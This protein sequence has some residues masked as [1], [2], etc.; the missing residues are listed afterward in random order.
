MLCWI[1]FSTSETLIRLIIKFNFILVKIRVLRKLKILCEQVAS[2][3]C[4]WLWLEKSR[5]EAKFGF[6]SSIFD[7]FTV[8][9]CTFW[10]FTFAFIVISLYLSYSFRIIFRYRH[11]S[12][13]AV[14]RRKRLYLLII[15]AFSL[16]IS[17]YIWYLKHLLQTFDYYNNLM[18]LFNDTI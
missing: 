7:E 9:S 18:N 4:S 1:H 14:R 15:S 17:S 2:L 16:L 8:R 5:M 13:V 10:V 11:E 12:I 6:S 3:F